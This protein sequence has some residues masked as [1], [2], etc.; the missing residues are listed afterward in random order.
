MQALAHT[1]S[2]QNPPTFSSGWKLNVLN[3]L[4]LWKIC[5]QDPSRSS[6][7]ILLQYEVQLE[8]GPNMITIRHLNRLRVEW[9]LNHQRGRPRSSP[10]SEVQPEQKVEVSS[11]VLSLKLNVPNL[12]IHLFDHWLE[13]QGFFKGVV[14]VL[15]RAI[16][17]YR[18][19]HHEESFPLLFHRFQTLVWRLKALFYA[20]LFG[21]GKLTRY[22]IKE[23]GLASVIGRS[24][25]SSTL[26]QFLGQL[27]RI[28][29]AESLKPLLLPEYVGN[30]VYID[31]HM[32]PFWTSQKM[33]KGK[34]TM[35]GRI[36]AGT[37]LVVAHDEQG[38]ILF[39]Y[40]YA[41]DYCLSHVIIEYC[42]EIVAASGIKV[43]VIDREINSLKMALEFEGRNW[44]LLS[45]L[46]KNE[47][48]GLSSFD[49]EF[50]EGEKGEELYRGQWKDK[51]K[52]EQDP[53]HFVLVVKDESVQAYWGT[54]HMKEEFFEKDWPSIY[55]Q[56]NELQEN[57]FKRMIAHGALN[58]NYGTK[59][60]L[61]PDRHQQRAQDKLK[62]RIQKA[63]PGTDKKEKAITKQLKKVEES[64]EKE[65]GRRLSQ[66]K[67][68]LKELQDD[69]KK[70]HE[71]KE[72]LVAKL[73]ALGEPEERADRD[74][75]KQNVMTWRTLL[76]ENLLQKFLGLLLA[77]LDKTISIETLIDLLF[78]RS[79]MYVETAI[80]RTYWVS[81]K[82]LSESYKV[83]LSQL[84]NS[85]NDMS[86]QVGGK[87]VEIQLRAGPY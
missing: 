25:Q 36:M 41:P 65:H 49:V 83:L 46:D 75:R 53:R 9:G 82:G 47:Y 28:N 35:L 86:L 59:K 66:R 30:R 24:Y 73:E 37:Q 19:Q 2:Y 21:L 44:G 51:K 67:C 72:Q 34:I 6:C 64:E 54:S 27:E 7:S 74:L 16:S 26:N 55:R 22:D 18:E 29:A 48:D 23:H 81:S 79:C 69:K 60:V 32:V 40:S 17:F 3:L 39:F 76:L 1:E 78:R 42:K 10:F 15:H 12:G 80:G 11:N 14:Q 5:I 8:L 87:P 43:F 50:L 62:I 68:K 31:G 71:K 57:S 61:G 56:R 52:H 77:P 45:M 85:L 20:S 84:V 70:A 33:H 13:Q 58:I 4:I 38:Q 63:Q